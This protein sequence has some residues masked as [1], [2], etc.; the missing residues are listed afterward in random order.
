MAVDLVIKNGTVVSLLG[1]LKT[2]IAIAG[3]KILAVGEQ[4]AFAQTERVIDA[5]GKIVIPGGIDPHTHFEINFMG[6][7]SPETWDIATI[8]AIR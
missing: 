5:T 2:D 1:V 7:A 8:A 3:E 6:E 4:G